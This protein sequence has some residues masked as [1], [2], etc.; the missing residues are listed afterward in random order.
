[1]CGWLVWFGLVEWVVGFAFA[2]SPLSVVLQLQKRELSYS[3]S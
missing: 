3:F 1:V 2:V